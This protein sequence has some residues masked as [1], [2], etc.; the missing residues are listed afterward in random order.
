MR[1]IDM[2][3]LSRK[4]LVA[5]MIAIPTWLTSVSAQSPSKADPLKPYTTCKLPGDLK[6]KEVT[7]RPKSMEKYREVTTT[8]GNE[9]VSVLDG[10]RVMF[11]YKDV[12]YYYANVK[13]EQ[14]DSANYLQDKEKVISEL[15]YDSPTKP[16][17]TGIIYTGRTMLNG[18]EHYGF[19]RDRID[20]GGTMGVHVLFY[21]A[22]HLI[23]T[24]YLLNQD[25]KNVF[26]AQFGR[27]RFTNIEEYR[28]LKDDFLNHY[29]E[30]L[31]GV[32]DAQ[33]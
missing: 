26:R 4:I 17:A 9:R 15:K 5:L 13:I 30:C 14:S 21:D 2:S 12:L 29:S 8:K 31:K 27:R 22:G 23:I 32:A 16:A 20:V 3:R 33:H 10:Y 24:I 6:V 11:A 18:F 7:R 25:D 28:T 19:D 1:R